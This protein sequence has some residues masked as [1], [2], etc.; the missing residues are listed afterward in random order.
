MPNILKYDDAM[1]HF[2]QFIDDRGDILT[3]HNHNER[4]QTNK[5]SI[6]NPNLPEKQTFYPDTNK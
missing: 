1:L 5:K 3:P 2:I 4:I 6:A